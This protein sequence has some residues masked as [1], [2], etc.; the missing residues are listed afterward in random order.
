MAY[1]N[2]SN[3]G[4]CEEP[5]DPLKSGVVVWHSILSAMGLLKINPAPSLSPGVSGD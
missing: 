5:N 4:G 2:I 1:Q 3:G